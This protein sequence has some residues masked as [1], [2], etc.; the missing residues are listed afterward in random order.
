[1]GRTNK[2][3][4]FSVRSVEIVIPADAVFFLVAVRLKRCASIRLFDR[5]Q[6]LRLKMDSSSDVSEKGF[7][8]TVARLTST[9]GAHPDLL[10]AERSKRILS[11]GAEIRTYK[12]V[13]KCER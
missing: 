2:K 13:E 3:S 6:D 9:L 5:E 10:L 1:M 4:Q 12:F 7:D 11:D 8:D